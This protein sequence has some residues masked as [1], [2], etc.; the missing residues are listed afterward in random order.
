MHGHVLSKLDALAQ[1]H[2]K[3]HL[4]QLVG[5]VREGIVA[6]PLRRPL[7]AAK[8]VIVVYEPVMVASVGEYIF[9][10]AIIVDHEFIE[11][12]RRECVLPLI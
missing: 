10:L 1:R 8:R 11:N 4:Q 7:I 9:R 5:K 12:S 6:Q 3:H 2:F